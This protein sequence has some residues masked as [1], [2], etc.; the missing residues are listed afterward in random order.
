VKS[1]PQSLDMLCC[2]KSG[3]RKWITP[4]S[5]HLSLPSLSHSELGLYNE[6]FSFQAEKRFPQTPEAPCKR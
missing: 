3:G 1:K 6:A 5:T 4:P 2:V